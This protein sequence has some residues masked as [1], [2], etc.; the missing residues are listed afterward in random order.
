MIRKPKS[1]LHNTF[2]KSMVW[3]SNF[4]LYKAIQADNDAMPNYLSMEVCKFDMVI[5]DLKYS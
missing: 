2:V 3:H 4:H 5:C 1:L